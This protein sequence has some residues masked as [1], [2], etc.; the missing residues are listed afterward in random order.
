MR[1][2]G[3]PNW[4]RVEPQTRNTGGETPP[5]SKTMSVRVR[6]PPTRGSGDGG[7]RSS[8]HPLYYLLRRNVVNV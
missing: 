3:P 2:V 7:N 1:A 6:F 5:V 8:P 4:E